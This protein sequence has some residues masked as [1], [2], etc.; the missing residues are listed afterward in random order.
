[1]SYMSQLAHFVYYVFPIYIARTIDPDLWLFLF[2]DDDDDDNDD[3]DD[4]TA[5]RWWLALS[6]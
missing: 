5:V 4:A 1:M 6:G 3:D 2:L